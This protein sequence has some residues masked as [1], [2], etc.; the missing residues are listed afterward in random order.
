[1]N[2]ILSLRKREVSLDEQAAK[3]ALNKR[4]T[5]RRLRARNRPGLPRQLGNSQRSDG[6]DRAGR[7]NAGNGE[8]APRAG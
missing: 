4:A 5:S 1:V 6:A 2:A 7:S 8:A 3:L